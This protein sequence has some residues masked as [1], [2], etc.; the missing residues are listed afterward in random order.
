M[1]WMVAQNKIIRFILDLPTRSS[2]DNETL[3]KL[4]MPR[5]TDWANQLQFNHTFNIY[6]KY[7]PKYLNHNFTKVSTR[8][9]RTRFSKH[10]FI[11]P[12]ATTSHDSGTFFCHT[13]KDW[14]S[15]PYSIKWIDNKNTFKIAVKKHLI[16]VRNFA[17]VT[18]QY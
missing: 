14:N 2:I 6:H 7:C 17:N 9:T 13:I 4:D 18:Y 8:R 12:K 16:E 11:L 5:V 1:F 10:N 3:N 15:L